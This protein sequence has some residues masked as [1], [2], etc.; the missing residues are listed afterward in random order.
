MGLISKIF[1]A[2]HPNGSGNKDTNPYKRTNRKSGLFSNTYKN[3]GYRGDK[4]EQEQIRRDLESKKKFH[5]ENPQSERYQI[6]RSN[7]LYDDVALAEKDAANRN[8]DAKVKNAQ[9][10]STAIKSFD[11]DPKKEDLDI[12]FAGG[13]KKYRFPDV[14]SEVVSEWMEAPSKGKFYNAVIKQYSTNK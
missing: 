8:T 3:A 9:V 7:T 10:A 1:N 11:Y 12:Q 13:S 6:N 14:P 2:L 4:A 5:M